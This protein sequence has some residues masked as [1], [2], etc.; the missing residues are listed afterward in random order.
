MKAVVDPDICIGCMLCTQVCPGVFK[1]EQDKAVAYLTP[2]PAELQEPCKKA[3]Q[4]CPVEAIKI[5][6]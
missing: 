2:V 1:M 4:D 3:A 6:Q 5:S